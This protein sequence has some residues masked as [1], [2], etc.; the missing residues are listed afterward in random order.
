MNYILMTWN[1]GP[2]DDLVF[3][4]WTWLEKMVEPWLAGTPLNASQWSVGQHVN[5]IGPGDTALLYRQGTWGRGIVARGTVTTTPRTDAHWEDQSKTANYVSIDWHE[6]VPIEM[7]VDLA[8][9]EALAPDFGWRKVYGS[10]WS[11][12]SDAGKAVLAEW[13]RLVGLRLA[14]RIAQEW[15]E[16]WFEEDDEAD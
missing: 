13:S 3:D 16:I 12:P 1:P 2:A 10:G 14:R 4:Q 5:G 9:L 8:D 15:V 7:R 11:L 6:A